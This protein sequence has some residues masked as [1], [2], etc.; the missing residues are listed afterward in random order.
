MASLPPM[1]SVVGAL[2]IFSYFYNK[3]PYDI[4]LDVYGPDRHPD[5]IVEKVSMLVQSPWRFIGQLDD[6][7]Q[8]KLIQA[9][10]QDSQEW[11]PDQ[12]VRV[13][14]ALVNAPEAPPPQA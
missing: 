8:G 6:L 2:S 3:R 13:L 7:H 9:A 11:V 14:H 12:A 5:Y 10:I 1:T 4:F